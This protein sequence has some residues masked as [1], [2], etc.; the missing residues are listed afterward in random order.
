VFSSSRSSLAYCHVAATVALFIE[1]GGMAAPT[2][3]SAR[4]S[5]NGPIPRAMQAFIAHNTVWIGA[6]G[7]SGQALRNGRGDVIGVVTAQH[8]AL[9]AMRGDRVRGSDGKTYGVFAAPIMARTGTKS[10]QL[11]TVARLDSFVVPAGGEILTHDLVFGVAAGHTSEEVL[12]GYRKEA[13]TE[14]QMTGLRVGQR[15]YFGGYPAYQPKYEPFTQAQEFERQSFVA[16]VLAL[17]LLRAPMR[18]FFVAAVQSLW[19]SVTNTTDGATSSYGVSGAVGIV[20]FHGKWRAIGA[21]SAFQDLKGTL[22]LRNARDQQVGFVPTLGENEITA[23]LAFAY[24]LPRISYEIHA[25]RSPQRIPGWTPP[26]QQ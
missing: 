16:K 19:V 20:R 22:A 4:V 25:V 23:T 11:R 9:L 7:C 10:T 6:L 21:A 3:A 15:V 8:C 14:K 18:S 5:S 1:L 2:V 17:G 13:L 26:T 12:A 24:Q